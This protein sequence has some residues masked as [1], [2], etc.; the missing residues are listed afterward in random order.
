MTKNNDTQT[1]QQPAKPNPALKRLD[2][3]VGTWSIKGRESGPDGEIHGQ[4]T[5]EWMEGGFFLVQHVDIDYIG[6]K[7]K[8]IEYIEYDEF[9]KACT[10]HYF[11][12]EGHVFTYAWEVNDDDITIWFGTAGSSKS[13]QR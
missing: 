6:R 4:V 3:L 9:S 8:G 10:S 7:I 2:T 11:D 1:P 13:F 12:N 5:F